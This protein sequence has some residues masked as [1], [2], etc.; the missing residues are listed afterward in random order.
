M[1]LHDVRRPYRPSAHR[2]A[3]GLGMSVG[4]ASVA[5]AFHLITINREILALE[6][7]TVGAPTIVVLIF[8][9]FVMF[10]SVSTETPPG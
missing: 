9:V 4:I 2:L 8:I 1:G 3:N 6:T 7:H 10:C 5:I